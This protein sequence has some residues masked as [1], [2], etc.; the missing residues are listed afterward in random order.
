MHTP[1]LPNT[2][3]SD[4]GFEWRPATFCDCL[5]EL[6]HIRT[7]IP[8][9]CYYRGQRLSYRLLDS[10]FARK[11]KERRGLQDT[12]RYTPEQRANT[13]LQHELRE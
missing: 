6:E 12:Q 8:E 1:S 10:T 7:L 2:L 13:A 9:C 4:D 11:M 5:I 3:V